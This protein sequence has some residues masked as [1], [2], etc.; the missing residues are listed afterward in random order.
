MGLFLY[1]DQPVLTAAVFDLVGREV[2]ATGL[3]VVSFASVLMATASPLVAGA[4][5]ETA[6]F[7]ATAYYNASLFAIAAIVFLLL[8]VSQGPGHQPE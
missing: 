3:G 2:S 5:Y 4:L 7:A 8:P 6:G 1:P